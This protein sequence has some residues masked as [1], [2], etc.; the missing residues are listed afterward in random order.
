MPRLLVEAV[1]PRSISMLLAAVAVRFPGAVGGCRGLPESPPQAAN[2]AAA[3]A[4]SPKRKD[5]ALGP[6]AAMAKSGSFF[7]EWAPRRKGSRRSASVVPTD[8]ILA[9]LVIPANQAGSVSFRL[10]GKLS[11]E[12]G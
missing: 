10:F 3:S 6:T 1:Q 8:P 12:S 5:R 2:D 7:I 11:C 9:R 4:V